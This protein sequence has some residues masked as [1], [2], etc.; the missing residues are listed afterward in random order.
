MHF[1]SIST[2]DIAKYVDPSLPDQT[3]VLSIGDQSL[4]FPFFW[5]FSFWLFLITGLEVFIL[6]GREEDTFL[7]L[8]DDD[9]GIG[10]TFLN[11]KSIS[12]SHCW[13]CCRWYFLIKWKFSWHLILIWVQQQ[14][15]M[16]GHT[17]SSQHH[18][19]WFCLGPSVISLLLSLKLIRF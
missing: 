7:S 1:Y 2:T 10:F 12:D 4:H 11:W 5:K 18:F 14:S 3:E 19:I 15:S 9:T 16:G 17:L 8:E 13:C 6:H